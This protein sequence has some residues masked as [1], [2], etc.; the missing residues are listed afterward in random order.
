MI[1]K[2]LLNCGDR[3]RTKHRERA[4]IQSNV[5][6]NNFARILTSNKSKCSL[7]ENNIREYNR[8]DLCCVVY[9]LFI[10][11]GPVSIAPTLSMTHVLNS[12]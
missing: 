8:C 10:T 4:S 2:Q 7:Q 9:I 1:D 12:E 6:E 5:F 11:C 3:N